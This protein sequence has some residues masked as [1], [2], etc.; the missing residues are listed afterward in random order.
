MKK[1]NFSSISLILLVLFSLNVTLLYS[2]SSNSLSLW[3]F[4]QLINR[5]DNFEDSYIFI[6]VDI[7]WDNNGNPICTENGSQSGAKIC[8][9]G[10]GGVIIVWADGRG[11][12]TDIYSQRLNPSGIAQWTPNGTPIC[13]FS[14][15]QTQHQICSDG[16]GGAIITWTD[17]RDGANTDI[18]AQRIDSNGVVN[19]T[20]NGIAICT[21]DDVQSQPEICSD[22]SGGAIIVWQD[23]RPG[24]ANDDIYAQR[25]NSAG[26]ALWTPN[27]TLICDQINWQRNPEICSDGVG[28]AILTWEDERNGGGIRHI[29]AQRIDGIGLVQ[30]L[31]NGIAI[32]TETNSKYYPEICSD[33]NGG[34]IIAWEDHRVSNIDRNIY[35]HKV[36]SNGNLLWIDNGTPIC[37]ELFN[38]FTP[39]I[40]SDGAGG[41]IITWEDERGV[42]DDIYAQRIN[43]SGYVEWTSNGITICIESNSQNDASISSDG[44][45]GAIITWTDWRNGSETDIYAQQ[46]NS[47]GVA[48][49]TMNGIPICTAIDDQM[50]SFVFSKGGEAF[51]TWADRRTGTLYDDLYAQRVVFDE[52]PPSITVYSPPGNYYNTPPVMDVDFNDDYNLDDA[53]YKVDSFTP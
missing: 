8:S 9:D 26:V 50:G 29:F 37:T 39:Q 1:N 30:W 6:S 38:Q 51:I 35:V 15:S 49:W 22:G 43:S 13:Q 32:C 52:T 21:E 11:A 16:N 33:E 53:Y 20:I 24:G 18:Y 47:T 31:A 25:I 3:S 46:I 5:I 42:D 19:W 2:N 34:A 41:A 40:C 12:D 44:A 4:T 28:G 10:D 27:G 45:G 48:Q 7:K 17:Y 14:G 36:D 23:G